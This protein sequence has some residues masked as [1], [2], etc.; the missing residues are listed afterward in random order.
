[1]LH[2]IN[3]LLALPETQALAQFTVPQ[4]PLILIVGCARSGTTLLTQWLAS[5]GCFGYPTNLLSRFYRAPYIGALIQQML[6]D[7][8]LGVG[9]ELCE[10]Q[11]SSKSFSSELGKTKGALAP[12]EFWYFWRRF[13]PFGETQYLDEDTLTDV[14]LK[15]LLAELAAIESVFG[16][17]LAM[18]GMIVNWNITFVNRL[19]PKA[20]FLYIRRTPILNAQSLLESRKRFFG[21]IEKWYSFKPPEYETLKNLD[22][23]AQVAGQVYF[24]NRAITEQL[25]VIDPARYLTVDYAEFCDSPGSLFQR[26]LD[27]LEGQQWNPGSRVYT[28]PVAFETSDTL[29]LACDEC[30]RIA[31]AYSGFSGE[32]ACLSGAARRCLSSSQG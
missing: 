15:P 8:E 29:R 12:H 14:D 31:A 22:P 11:Q 26:L 1:L 21:S 18:K 10:L 19:L 27:K 16:K 32:P 2:R 13:F 7:P 6:T 28:G 25:E 9:D 3:E 17:P 5:L 20:L 4:H 24:T 30:S 23:Y